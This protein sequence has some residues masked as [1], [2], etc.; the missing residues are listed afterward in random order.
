MYGKSEFLPPRRTLTLLSS[1]RR[2]RVRLSGLAFA[3]GLVAL[4]IAAQPQA[5]PAPT[6]EAERQPTGAPAQKASEAPGVSPS[7]APKPTAAGTAAPASSEAPSRSTPPGAGQKP[8]GA[9]AVEPTA[10]VSYQVRLTELERK[11]QALKERIRQSHARLALLSE[12]IM[13]GAETGGMVTVAFENDLSDAWR[14]VELVV[15]LDGVVQYKKA[16]NTGALSA[17]KLIP[18]FQGSLGKGDHVVQVMMKLRGHGFG[19]F[20][21]LKGLEASVRNDY[22]FSLVSGKVVEVQV[23]AWEEGGPTTSAEERPN[24]RFDEKSSG[25]GATNSAPGEQN[26]PSTGGV[27]AA[28]TPG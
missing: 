19:L 24:L 15:V 7:P 28:E 12:H 20:S 21:Y 27:R 26:Q 8:A 10:G 1:L 4:E 23:T 11:I 17:Q 22:S 13:A 5:V 6:Q 18:I 9:A 14:I 3:W 2:F 25:G 16:D